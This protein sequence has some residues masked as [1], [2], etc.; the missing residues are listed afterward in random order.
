MRSFDQ[1]FKPRADEQTLATLR[2]APNGTTVRLRSIIFTKIGRSSWANDFRAG[3][4]DADV[5]S[6][7]DGTE[8]YDTPHN[9]SE[10][11]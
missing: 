1:R 2:T 3:M 4:S 10:Q 6:V 8:T 7:L 11:Q 9:E 5:A